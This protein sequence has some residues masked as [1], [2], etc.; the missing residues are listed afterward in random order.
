MTVRTRVKASLRPA[1]ELT[2]WNSLCVHLGRTGQMLRAEPDDGL[3]LGIEMRADAVDRATDSTHML[4]FAVRV[5]LHGIEHLI[6][7][8][9]NREHGM[10]RM[11]PSILAV[12]LT[13]VVHLDRDHA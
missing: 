9:D 5:A 2:V 12:Q 6:E 4:I 8:A 7:T 13:V 10:I 11:S 3:L 1:H